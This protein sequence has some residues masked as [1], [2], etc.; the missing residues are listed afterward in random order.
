M[1]CLGDFVSGWKDW[2]LFRPVEEEKIDRVQYTS[3]WYAYRLDL[4]YYDSSTPP[5]HSHLNSNHRAKEGA[6]I[7]KAPSFSSQKLRYRDDTKAGFG[8]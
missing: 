8:V 7:S 4:Y 1:S 5:G 2:T 6:E 3:S